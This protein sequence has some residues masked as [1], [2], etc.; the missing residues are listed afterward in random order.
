MI[1]TWLE[2]QEAG[3]ALVQTLRLDEATRRIPILICSSDPAEVKRRAG[4]LETTPGVDVLPKPFDPEALLAKV[5]Q[6]MGGH[7]E[8]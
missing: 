2:V 6:M 7:P 3:W 4:Q 8:G 5:A 1:D